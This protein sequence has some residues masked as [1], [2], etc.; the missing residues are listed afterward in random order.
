MRGH[1]KNREGKMFD[2]TFYKGDQNNDKMYAGCNV[3][4]V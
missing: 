4:P 2:K 3:I 1:G